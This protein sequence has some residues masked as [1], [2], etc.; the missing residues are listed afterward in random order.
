[1]TARIAIAV[2]AVL[3]A[4]PISSFADATDAGPTR[5]NAVAAARVYLEAW[6]RAATLL[7]PNPAA[8]KAKVKAAIRVVK[9]RPRVSKAHCGHDEVWEVVWPGFS[10][11]VVAKHLSGP[12]AALVA[13]RLHVMFAEDC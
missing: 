10:A 1:V 13:K 9:R 2:V 8:A 6:I 3:L 7:E 4:A 12:F 5:R 11:V